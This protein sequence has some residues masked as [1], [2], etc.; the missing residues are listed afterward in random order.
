MK[1]YRYILVLAILVYIF[2][3]GWISNETSDS[4]P[5][6]PSVEIHTERGAF[7]K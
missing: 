6:G 5:R 3:F 2:G 1:Y 7:T 4:Q